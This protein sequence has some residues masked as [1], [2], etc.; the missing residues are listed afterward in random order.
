MSANLSPVVMFVYNR[1]DNAKTTLEHLQRNAL[2]GQTVLYIFSDG[3]KDETSWKAVRELRDFLHTI[4]GFKEVNIIERD[5]N[6]Y[7]ERNIIE[8][9]AEVFAKHDRA[10]VLEDDICTSPVFLTYM[11]D[12]LNHYEQEKRV[13][14]IAG[15]SNLSVPEYGDVYFT[16]HMSGWGWATW[17]DRWQL[18][19]HYMTRAEALAGMSADL[20]RRIEYDGAFPCLK[21]LDRTPIPWDICWEITIYKH[22]GLCLTPTRTL[23]RNIGLTSGTHFKTFRVFGWYEFDRPYRTE[24]IELNNIPIESNQEIEALYK[25]AFVDHGMRYNLLGKIV[26]FLYKKTIA[27]R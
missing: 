11:N 13:M 16:P 7:L 3:G 4:T 24:K 12:A 5:T 18:F 21:S 6:F 27:R 9:L 20:I 15:F 10:I 8:G 17:R 25:K 23:V 1:L 2:A 22:N 14:H 26:R 19:T